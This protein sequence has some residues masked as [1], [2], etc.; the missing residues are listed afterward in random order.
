MQ[1]GCMHLNNLLAMSEIPLDLDNDGVWLELLMGQGNLLPRQTSRAAISREV[2]RLSPASPTTQTRPALSAQPP[3]P[4]AVDLATKT[5]AP[6]ALLPSRCRVSVLSA[7]AAV[8]GAALQ[9]QGV[10]SG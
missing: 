5:P 4:G 1:L 8:A 7:Y 6:D 3:Q 9:I 2:T 10:R